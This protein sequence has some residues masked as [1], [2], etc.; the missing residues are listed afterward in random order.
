[1]F[2]GRYSGQWW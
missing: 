2:L 1:V